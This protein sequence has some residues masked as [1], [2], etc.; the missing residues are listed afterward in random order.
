MTTDANLY[1]Q[2]PAATELT[3]RGRLAEA[4]ALIERT[5]P[6]P[7]AG[8]DV[9]GVRAGTAADVVDVDSAEGAESA[10]GDGTELLLPES[11]NLKASFD[12]LMLFESLRTDM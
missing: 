7:P 11:D 1:A 2:I 8:S 12:T 4:D 10:R 6:A 9:P 5:R 3:R